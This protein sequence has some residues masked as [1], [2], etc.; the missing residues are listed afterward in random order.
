MRRFWIS[1]ALICWVFCFSPGWALPQQPGEYESLLAAAQQAQARGDFSSAAEYYRQAVVLR[2]ELAEL[3]TNLGLMYYQTGKNE[4]AAEV[5]RQALR[6]KPALFVPN[7]FLGLDFVRLKRFA[8]AIPYLKRAA[9][10]KPTDIQAQLGLGQAYAGAGNTRLAVRS[11]WQATQIERGNADAWY[12]LGVSCLEQVEADARILLL[13]EKASGYL[14]ALMGDNFSEQHAYIQAAAAYQKAISSP[15]FPPGVHA[16]Y[17]FALLNRHDLPAAERE[18]KSEQALSPG[19]LMGKLGVARLDVEQGSMDRA[20]KVIEEIWNTDPGFL[21]ANMPVF[22]R[23]LPDSK[24]SEL[25]QV[26]QAGHATGDVSEGVVILFGNGGA[27]ETLGTSRSANP[28]R[29]RARTSRSEDAAILYRH[30]KYAA[31][32]ESLAPRLRLLQRNEVR[33]L[34]WCAYFSGNYRNAFDAASRLAVNTATEA[35][36]LYWETRS[37][38]RLAT[39]ALARASETDPNSPKLHMLLGDIARQR[40]RFPEAEQEYRKALALQPG[41]TG[42]LF[43]LSLAL[44][45]DDQIDQAFAVAQA[46]LTRNANDPELNAVM[47]E[48]L[49]VRR[50]FVDAEPYL[51]KG[52]N[53]KPEYV[54]HVHALLGKVY[55]QTS[56]P[57]QAI[58]ELKLALPD[59][60]DGTLHYQIARLYLKM[61]DRDSATKAFEVSKRLRAEG[62]NRATVALQQGEDD[63]ESR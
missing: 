18:L 59:D 60:K 37:A 39:E 24:L 40:K 16:D 5:F 2:P 19:S 15:G 58:A 26:V 21:R 1:V 43:G 33:L 32:T 34:T 62:L 35:E 29:Q 14:S 9:T 12:R 51:K 28:A 30:G 44:L 22:S 41:D 25:Q 54:P 8:G 47:G 23:G 36:G 17:A 52:L 55:A 57:Q 56:R 20:T 61:G 63:G 46:A 42:A 53:T 48:I 3:R 4:Q 13:K 7:L 45:A 10:L 49:C 38:Q 31:C 27:T 11:Y 6:L 50:E